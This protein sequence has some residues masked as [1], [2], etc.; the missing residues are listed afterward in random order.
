[1]FRSGVRELRGW[2]SRDARFQINKSRKLVSEVAHSFLSL[3]GPDEFV[4]GFAEP[5]FTD[6]MVVV[7]GL[8]ETSGDSTLI[9]GSILKECLSVRDGVA[10]LGGQSTSRFKIPQELPSVGAMFGFNERQVEH[11]LYCSRMVAK[12]DSVA[13]QDGFDLYFHMMLVSHSGLWSVIQQSR[14]PYTNSVRRYHWFS[15]KLRSFV[16]E[17]HTGIV[18]EEKRLRVLDMTAEASRQ[19]RKASLELLD[20]D[21]S[22]LRRIYLYTSTPGQSTLD[23]ESRQVADF[24]KPVGRVNWSLLCTL[25]KEPPRNYEELIAVK[26]VGREIVR[27]LAFGGYVLHGVRPSLADPAI[28]PAEIRERYSE[29][30]LL[31]RLQQVVDAVRNSQLPPELKR[32]GLTRLAE[33]FGEHEPLAG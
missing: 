7:G 15:G 21:I 33:V 6:F 32:H 11:L 4:S 30:Q 19:S 20:E 9:L 1:M 5:Y 8:D 13:L 2:S 23:D 25:Q 16:E 29:S 28:T 24:L 22:R 17:P 3:Y 27:L 10:V 14:N 18:S 12:T 26:M 31:W